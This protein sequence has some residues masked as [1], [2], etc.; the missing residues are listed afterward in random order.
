[1]IVVKRTVET[2]FDVVSWLINGVPYS[3]TENSNITNTLNFPASALHSGENSITM[4]VHFT[5]TEA[6]SLYTGK[7][8]LNSVAEF[9]A[10]NIFYEDLPDTVFCAKNVDFRAEIEG[11]LHP[12]EGRIQWFIDGE[13]YFLAR[14]HLEWSKNFDTTGNYVIEMLVRFE[15]DATITITSTLKMKIF[16]VKMRS[17][18]KG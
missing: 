2:P 7:V 17:I 12:D 3:I 13:E 10:N 14:D 11:E 18:K 9:Y 8:W 15:N 1:M 16:W 5:E 6:D 4:S